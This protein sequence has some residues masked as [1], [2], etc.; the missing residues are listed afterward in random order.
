MKKLISLLL[1]AGSLFTL[2]SCSKDIP[3]N[4]VFSPED[5]PGKTVGVP[6]DT[7]AYCY[8]ESFEE[9]G[10]ALE[11]YSSSSAIINDVASGRLD[12][13]IMNRELAEDEVSAFSK[14]K[15]LD[16]A[17]ISENLAI[18]TAFESAS[19]LSV[20]DNTL[21]TL[22]ENGTIEDII[23]NYI[24]GKEFIYTS[25]EDIQYSG[26]IKLAVNPIG[27]PFAYYNELGELAGMDIDIARAICDIM[28]VELQI[29]DADGN[30]LYDFIRSGRADFALG[31]LTKNEDTEELVGFTQSYYTCEQV[32]IVR[33]K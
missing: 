4:A 21:G 22:I 18:I 3:G 28:G 12:C 25:P 14:V 33:K 2:C 9:I 27:K 13:A 1:I 23:D 30:D 20:I 29:V 19:L 31:C 26:S 11:G 15:I 10:I 7:S 6:F 8:S 24:N 32:I 17:V 5:L 16:E